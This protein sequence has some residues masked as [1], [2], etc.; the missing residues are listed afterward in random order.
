MHGFRVFNEGWTDRRSWRC[1]CSALPHFKFRVC[2]LDVWH[3]WQVVILDLAP[4]FI[5]K[6][7]KVWREQELGFQPRH[8]VA[9]LLFQLTDQVINKDKIHGQSGASIPLVSKQVCWTSASD[10]EL[11]WE[12]SLLRH[13]PLQSPSRDPRGTRSAGLP[14][15]LVSRKDT[16]WDGCEETFSKSTAEDCK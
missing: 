1:N 12:A 4:E 10:A 5:W 7:G 15:A 14:G 6:E 8:W 16:I 13:S 9:W 2:S 11:F 3:Q